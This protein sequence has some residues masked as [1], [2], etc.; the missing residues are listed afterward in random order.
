MVLFSTFCDLD[1]IENSYKQE[2]QA[3]R[4]VKKYGRKAN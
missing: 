2:I 3:L 1:F 4:E